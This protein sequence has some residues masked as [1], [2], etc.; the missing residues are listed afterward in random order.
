MDRLVIR[1]SEASESEQA[2]GCKQTRKSDSIESVIEIETD[3]LLGDGGVF[4]LSERELISF[5]V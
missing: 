3:D 1:E 4:D 2:H 5:C